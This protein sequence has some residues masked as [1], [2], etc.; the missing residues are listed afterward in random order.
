VLTHVSR[1]LRSCLIFDFR[2]MDTDD[3]T[4][5]AYATLS[6]AYQASEPMRAELGVL[7]SNYRSEDEYLTG[8]SE[9]LD[10]ILEAP[11]DYIESWY[12]NDEIE[13]KTFT[14]AVESVRAHVIST[15]ATPRSKRGKPP[16][17]K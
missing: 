11:G 9:F 14:K 7:A 8:I 13:V 17:E 6:L 1:H 12:L 4:P 15:L 2:Q 3:L 10:A 5:M 16:F